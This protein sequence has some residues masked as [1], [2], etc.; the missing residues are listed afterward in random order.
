MYPH[1]MQMWRSGTMFFQN[2]TAILFM[3]PRAP[4]LGGPT[5]TSVEWHF[6]HFPDFMSHPLGLRFRSVRP[7][8]ALTSER[9]IAAPARIGCS[10][11][12]GV[13]SSWSCSCSFRSN[14][15]RRTV[16]GVGAQSVVFGHVE[17]ELTI[18]TVRPM[19]AVT[20]LTQAFVTLPEWRLPYSDRR[21]E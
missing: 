6:G 21:L 19:C 16:H 15:R 7:T 4:A 3:G 11:P 9:G 13:R 8:I 10:A 12:L 14:R 5:R 1:D 20:H 2:E 18:G 17:A